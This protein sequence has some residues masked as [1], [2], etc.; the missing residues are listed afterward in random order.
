MK[1]KKGKRTNLKRSDEDVVCVEVCNNLKSTTKR[2]DLPL[3]VFVQDPTR[4]VKPW[5]SRKYPSL[6]YPMSRIPTSW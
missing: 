1:A 5:N 4:Q 3:D 6:S 2:N